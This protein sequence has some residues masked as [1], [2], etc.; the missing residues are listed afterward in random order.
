MRLSNTRYSEIDCKMLLPRWLNRYDRHRPHSAPGWAQSDG[1]APL[2]ML[3]QFRHGTPAVLFG[4]DSFWYGVDVQGEALSNVIIT[5]LPFFPPDR[6]VVEA[7]VEAIQSAGGNAFYDYQVPQAVIKLKQ[8]FGRLIRTTTDRGMVVLFDPRVL[9]KAYGRV[10]LEAL[11]E[12]RRFQC[13]WPS[14]RRVGRRRRYGW[15]RGTLMTLSNLGRPTHGPSW[16]RVRAST[17]LPVSR[18]VLARGARA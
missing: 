7:R 12:C 9:T 3:A 5:R 8:G 17:P 2:Q 6:P 13:G 18:P 16:S 11:P 4:V 14:S 15:S 10:F 1:L